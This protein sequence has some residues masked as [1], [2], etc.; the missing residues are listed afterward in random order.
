GDPHGR[1]GA[2]LATAR[3]SGRQG[4]GYSGEVSGAD[5]ALS[6]RSA[7]SGDS[8]AM[9]TEAIGRDDRQCAIGQR[10]ACNFQHG[11]VRVRVSGRALDGSGQGVKCHGRQCHG[12]RGGEVVAIGGGRQDVLS[13]ACERVRHGGVPVV[14]GRLF[15]AHSGFCGFC[16][17]LLGDELLSGDAVGEAGGAGVG[18]GAPRGGGH[19][20]LRRRGGR[21]GRG[22]VAGGGGGGGGG[23]AGGGGGGGG[24]GG[25]VGGGCRGG[26]GGAPLCGAPLRGSSVNAADRGGGG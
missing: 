4:A 18:G 3:G 25:R 21:G 2:S 5:E 22:G 12:T 23:R 7:L 14:G 13:G 10:Y 20:R 11:G 1:G 8:Q 26:G 19:G 15:V 9:H 6:V 16:C 17:A 24:P